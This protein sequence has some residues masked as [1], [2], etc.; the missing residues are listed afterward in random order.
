LTLDA[1]TLQVRANKIKELCGIR[2]S[3]D[4]DVQKIAEKAT[5]LSM[6]AIVSLCSHTLTTACLR[7]GAEGA[8]ISNQD[9]DHAFRHVLPYAL[10]SIQ[11]AIPTVQFVDIGGLEDVKVLYTQIG[12]N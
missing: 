11:P 10:G 1:P 7:E 6:A 9:F 2:L 3:C 5:G 8:H 4:V 12:G